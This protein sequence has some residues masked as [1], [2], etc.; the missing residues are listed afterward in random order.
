MKLQRTGITEAIL[1]FDKWLGDKQIKKYS[2]VEAE[3]INWLYSS[4]GWYDKDIKGS[5]FDIDTEAVIL[6]ENYQKWKTDFAQA[7]RNCD[8]LEVMLWNKW[9]DAYFLSYHD[10]YKDFVRSFEAKD[11]S[12]NKQSPYY[13]YWENPQKMFP[14]LKGKVLVI[15]PMSPLFEKQYDNAHIV[16]PDMP[17]FDLVTATF[18]YCFFNNG[19]DKNGF[20]TLNRVFEELPKDFDTALVSIG[21]YGCL[22]A[23]KLN[24]LGKTTLTVGSGIPKLFA[25]DP[26]TDKPHWLNKIPDEFIPKDYKKIENGRYWIGGE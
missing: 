18:P 7:L 22:L 5:Y 9:I 21:P 12:L 14:F 19:P 23:D 6:S 17:Q 4:S 25:I 1:L 8:Y 11:D 13:N 16:Y 24:K 3:F 15:N 26:T 20:E 10:L 2:H